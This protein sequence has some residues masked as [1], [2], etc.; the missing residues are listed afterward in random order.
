MFEVTCVVTAVQT[1]LGLAALIAIAD[2]PHLAFN[3]RSF[4]VY[5]IDHAFDAALMA[6]MAASVTFFL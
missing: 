4:V 2:V 5:F 1:G 3:R 6:I